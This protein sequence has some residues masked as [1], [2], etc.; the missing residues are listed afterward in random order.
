MGQ[1]LAPSS[2]ESVDVLTGGYAP[3]YGRETAAILNVN[4]KSGTLNPFVDYFATGG[5]YSTFEA[6]L[7]AGGQ[8]GLDYGAADE[9]PYS[10]SRS[11]ESHS[12]EKHSCDVQLLRP[13]AEPLAARLT[14]TPLVRAEPTILVAFEDLGARPSLAPR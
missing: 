2:I 5:T 6:G 4:L 8:L 13:N 10:N 14:V 11:S 12:S 3:E 9:K 1:I 7:V